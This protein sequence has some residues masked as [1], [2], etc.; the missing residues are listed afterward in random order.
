MLFSVGDLLTFAVLMMIYGW[1]EC[2]VFNEL[3]IVKDVM[4]VFREAFSIH[5]GK[6]TLTEIN[7]PLSA[8]VLLSRKGMPG[9][10]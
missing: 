1:C 9:L 4:V 10:S 2:K 8:H 5:P 7:N 6:K 3:H